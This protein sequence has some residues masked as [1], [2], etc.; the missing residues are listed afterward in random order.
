MKY[1]I[2]EP[3]KESELA[4]Y[5]R[6]AASNIDSPNVEPNEENHNEANNREIKIH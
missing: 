6:N 5:S 2:F 4:G 1:C 3:Y